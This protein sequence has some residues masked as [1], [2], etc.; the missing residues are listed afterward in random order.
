MEQERRGSFRRF[1][2]SLPRFARV[3]FWVTLALMAFSLFLTWNDWLSR[4]FW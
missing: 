1:F 3:V 4:T 2:R